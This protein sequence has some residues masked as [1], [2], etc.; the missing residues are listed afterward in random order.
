MKTFQAQGKSEVEDLDAFFLV[1][2]VVAGDFEGT[3]CCI[4]S[5]ESLGPNFLVRV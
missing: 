4:E 1:G 2:R 3:S 5:Q